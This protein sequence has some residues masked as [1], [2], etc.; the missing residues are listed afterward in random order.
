MVK[1]ICFDATVSNTGHVSF[2]R[3]KWK[4]IFSIIFSNSSCRLLS[5]FA[6][7]GLVALRYYSSGDIKSNGA[8]ETKIGSAQ[9]VTI[10][11]RQELF[12]DY[13][14]TCYYLLENSCDIRDD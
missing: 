9:H 5:L 13:D 10:M 11:S 1:A 8:A 2:Y 3:R 12:P 6:C 14:K 4:R 7:D